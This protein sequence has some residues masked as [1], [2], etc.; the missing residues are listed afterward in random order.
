M[1]DEIKVEVPAEE[2][3]PVEEPKVEVPAE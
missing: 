2:T 3:K 1:T